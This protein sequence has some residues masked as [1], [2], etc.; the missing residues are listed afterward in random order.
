MAASDDA[1]FGNEHRPTQGEPC[2][3]GIPV[4][5]NYGTETDL[6]KQSDY[7]AVFEASPDAM[8][9]VDPEGMIRASI[10]KPSNCFGGAG[11]RLRVL[12]SND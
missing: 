1:H 11:R 3:D 8:L 12:R 10:G 5:S 4:D 6:L 7:T 2:A 9:V